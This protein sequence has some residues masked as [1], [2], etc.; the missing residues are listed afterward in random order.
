ME[1][2]VSTQALSTELKTGLVFLTRL[3][4]VPSAPIT[5]ADIAQASWTFP[6]IGVGI[7]AA[8]SLIYWIAHGLG[9]DALVGAVLA[10]AATLLITGALHEDGLADMADG[11]G[12]GA[13][14]ERKLEIMRDSRIGTY[15]VLALIISLM[16]RVGA[17]ASLAQPALVAL[18]LIAAHAGAR[19]TL[20]IFMRR[21]PRARADGLSAEAGAP[22]QQSAAIA[23]GIGLVV[24]WLCL[25]LAAA[26]IA[27]LLLVAALGFM[28]WLST[29]QIGGQTGDVLGAVEQA[30][31]ILI[32]LVA[33][34]WLQ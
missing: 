23:V 3:P 2:G 9:L 34:I 26:F 25:G 31:E 12:G 30:A 4:L 32:L 14:Q 13:T 11:F 7:G 5:G 28:A 15:G 17:V 24:V 19:A 8:A 21:V 16:L 1:G 29:R 6:V 33:A 27:F 10:V 22:P 18:G 20:P